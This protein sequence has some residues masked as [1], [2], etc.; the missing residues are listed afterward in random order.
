[1]LNALCALAAGL[2]KKSGKLLFLGLD[3]AGKTTL[4]HMLKDDRLAQHVPTLHPTSEEL[5]IGNMRFTTF[6][7]GGHTQARRVWKDYFPAV[8][9]I[10]FLIDAWDRSRFQESKIELDSL[11]TDE[12]L[13]NCPVLILGNKID[14]PGA[15]SED[16][17]R[18]FY[19]LYQLTTGKVRSGVYDTGQAAWLTFLL[20]L[21]REKSRDLNYPAVHWSCLCA[22]FSSDKDMVK[23]SAGW[24][25]TSIKEPRARGINSNRHRHLQKKK[26]KK[27][28][29]T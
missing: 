29:T 26:H 20:C 16:E 5:S 28:I 12:A 4:L 27:I 10:V 19:G 23:A 1:L 6:D 24:R 22:Q 25:N 8:D 15:A 18:N 13:S 2:Y 7:L 11:L 21:C 14:K 17:L 9:A 3:N